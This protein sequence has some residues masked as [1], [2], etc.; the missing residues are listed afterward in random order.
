MRA[1]WRAYRSFAYATARA[2]F[3]EALPR[4]TGA[5][6]ARVL[7]ALSSLDRFQEQGVRYAEEAVATARTAGDAA[8]AALAQ[9]RLGIVL[10]YH[11]LLGAALR[12]MEAAERVLA[13]IPDDALPELYDVQNLALVSRR[14]YYAL[15]LGYTG[16][17]REA[18][19][20][21]GEAPETALAS[22]RLANAHPNGAAAVMSSFL[23]LGRPDE[24]RQAV[25]AL[26]AIMATRKD[27]RTVLLVHVLNFGAQLMVPYL[28]DD[29]GRGGGTRRNARGISGTSTRRWAPCPPSST[30]ARCSSSPGSGR[31][32]GRSGD[33]G[34]RT[35]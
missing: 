14:N 9:F 17:W 19:A 27:G 6:R 7:L 10:A 3:D 24:A 21:L 4:A 11:S 1:A 13:S 22:L 30:A 8:L 5:E 29:R 31:R 32:R 16:R 35:P 26:A 33:S 28:L 23:L 20:A 25:A 34:A 2:R 15:V 18:F 12:A